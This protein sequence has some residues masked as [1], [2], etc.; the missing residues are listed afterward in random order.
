MQKCAKFAGAD[1]LAFS[2]F[3]GLFLFISELL[4]TY[5]FARVLLI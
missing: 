4:A 2:M 5:P 1:T 3:R